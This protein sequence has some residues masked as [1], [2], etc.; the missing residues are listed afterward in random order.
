MNIRRRT[1]EVVE[2]SKS[3]DKVSFV[4]DIVILLLIF[5]NV[6]AVIFG[7]MQSVQ[8][9]WGVFLNIFE[10]VSVVIFTIEYIIRLWACIVDPRFSGPVRGRLRLA[11]RAMSIIDLLSITPFYLP[12]I[13][14]D[15]RS[16]RVLRLLR[17][18]RVAKVTRYYS[19]LDLIK[20]VFQSKKEE[21]LLTTVLMG[22]LLVVSSSLLFYCEHPAQPDAFS[23]IPATMW[24][25]VIT[26]TTVGYG[27]MYPVTVLGK[28]CASVIAILGIG[29]FA[30]PTG[31][32]GAGFVEA[33]QHKREKQ[34]CPHCQKKLF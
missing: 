12:F 16:L 25:S 23:S 19:S 8:E 14:V 18:L 2:A 17:I 1:W 30:L 34:V 33:V 10:T 6:I 24:W 28:V 15:L 11:F 20:H 5:L 7:S 9:R 26:L 13:G 31:I 32:I 27:D 22:L 29:M 3:G 21:L 4:F